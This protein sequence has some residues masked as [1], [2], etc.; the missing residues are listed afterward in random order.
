MSAQYE[1][2]N[3]EVVDA[4]SSNHLSQSFSWLNKLVL[5]FPMWVRRYPNSPNSRS[6]CLS[7]L[8]L[9]I[10]ILGNIYHFIDA[11]YLYV[12]PSSNGFL[13]QV[14]V[15]SYEVS[16]TMARLL[17]LYYFH[18]QFNYPWMNMAI[19]PIS[20]TSH[21]KLIQ[22]NARIILSLF[23]VT[24][25]LD[26]MISI[27]YILANPTDPYH[28]TA[29]VIGT[30]T[31]FFPSWVLLAVASAIFVKYQLN[32]TILVDKLANMNHVDFGDIMDTYVQLYKLFKYEYTKCNMEN[33]R[34]LNVT[35]TNIICII[36]G[37]E[38]IGYFQGYYAYHT[39]M[40]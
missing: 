38:S 13:Y 24:I 21:I 31:V 1:Y 12:L 35:T 14:A 26:T 28:I 37:S 16:F 20:Q 18:R 32:L 29:E 23:T 22:I 39:N 4:P 8:I 34:C 5:Y 9:L 15:S 2:L 7:W 19:S 40:D 27:D 6:L 3:M 11:I 30:V 10:L 36:I 17:S 33:G 25:I